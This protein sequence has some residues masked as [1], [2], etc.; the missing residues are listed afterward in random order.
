MPAPQPR[1]DVILIND[2]AISPTVRVPDIATMPYDG[3]LVGIK[4]RGAGFEGIEIDFSDGQEAQQVPATDVAVDADTL[5]SQAGPSPGMEFNGFV[6]CNVPVAK[7][8]KFGMTE[9]GAGT[10]EGN[11]YLLISET[12]T[13]SY[14]LNVAQLKDVH[15][16]LTLGDTLID[17]PTFMTKVMRCFVRGQGAEDLSIAIG[18]KGP[19]IDLPCRSIPINTDVE[20]WAYHSIDVDVPDKIIYIAMHGFTATNAWLYFQLE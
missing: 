13:G 15:T 11:I 18:V 7:G 20:P 5:G 10:A 6:S 16:P 9:Q 17:L 4:A 19:T 2:P 8:T 12:P 14:I 1:F 3:Y